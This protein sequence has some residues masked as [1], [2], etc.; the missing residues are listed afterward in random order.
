MD[1]KINILK[2]FIFKLILAS[3]ILFAQ[4][5]IISPEPV[6]FG[7]IP[8]ESTADREVLVYNVSASS[9]SVNSVS[10]EGNDAALFNIVNNPGSFTLE[11]IEKKTLT[12]RF[13]PSNSEHSNAILKVETN[14]ASYS[15]SLFAIGISDHGYQT[16]ER[17]LGVSNSEGASEI[18]QTSDNG[19]II[20]G[21]TIP[22]GEKYSRIYLTKTDVHGKM[23]WASDYGDNSR[24]DA[25]VDVLA[26]E[27][28]YL[29]YS[30]TENF[31]AKGM[32]MML[33]QFNSSGEYQWK[34]LYGSVEDEEGVKFLQTSDG[35]YLLMGYTI[36]QTAEGKEIYIKKLDSDF[37]ESWTKK[38]G[39]SGG[40]HASDMIKLSDGNYGLVGYM[41][42]GENFQ[43][44]FAKISE[45]GDIIWEK[46]YGGS[47]W[48]QASSILETSDGGFIISGFTVSIGH[49]AR[50]GYLL[51]LDES[52]NELWQKAYGYE[53]S[54]VF[55]DVI[56]LSNGNYI[57]V[58]NS[59]TYFTQKKQYTD[60]Y[61]VKTDSKGNELT[62]KLY[63]SK[64][65]GGK[66]DDSLGEIIQANDGGYVSVG[67]TS[68]YSKSGD[69]YLIKINE[70]CVVSLDQE[71]GEN[72]KPGKFKLY[73]N[74][75]NPF[76]AFTK[77]KFSIPDDRT[78]QEVTL[79]IYDI[80]G[81]R[82]ATLLK[83]DKS[84]GIYEI[85][86]NAKNISSGIYFYQLKS[87]NYINTKKMV[88]IE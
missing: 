50:D 86:F 42:I 4:D 47:D 38:I 63:G 57:A 77:I 5:M 24:V 62:S 75:P 46:D 65:S 80:T 87:G 69:I 28:G 20:V 27:D 37:N 22:S 17:I 13:S 71:I 88:L 70:N 49:G 82:V 53:H 39:G 21:S 23:I 79:M 25:G 84:P 76:N 56:E 51:K 54:D 52:G 48:D 3:T 18:K 15:D 83:A 31:G 2:A 81:R 14:S 35:G 73:Q 78:K 7:K 45:S 6:Y 43:V 44:Y 40:Y 36:P 29:V 55:K 74:F 1:V 30:N 61:I 72:R 11:P 64:Y 16:F 8:V 59:I 67:G 12:I 66:F 68:S 19:F 26:N 34:K 41:N 58:G 33:V 32:D 10:I 85:V 9:I 60:A